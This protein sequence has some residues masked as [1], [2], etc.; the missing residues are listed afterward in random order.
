MSGGYVLSALCFAAISLVTCEISCR[1]EAGAS[2]D[3]FVVYKLPIRRI[4]A[5]AGP[6]LEYLYLDS[7]S[8]TWEV[9][10]F[11]INMSQGAV[12]RTL[13]QL[14]QSYNTNDTA[15]MMYNDSPPG[16]NNYTTQRGHSKG[17][18]FFDRFQGF[19][20]IH[21]VPHFP[22]FP[23][24]GFG[25]PHTGQQY[26]QSAICVTYRYDQFKEIASQ[27]LYYNPNAYNCSVPDLYHKELWSLLRICQGKSFPWIE[28]TR[29]V[30]LES[31]QGEVF[32]NFAK[33]KYFVDDIYAAWIAQK[34]GSDLLSETWQP[35]GMELPSNCS[36]P[37]HVYNIKRLAL[38]KISFYSL[39]DH[40]K[41]CV[42]KLGEDAWTCIG[43]LNRYPAQK[44]RSGGFI[45]TQNAVIYRAFSGMV[46]YYKA[47]QNSTVYTDDSTY[48]H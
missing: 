35:A 2:V 12:G 18:L 36:L 31:A 10:R 42:S 28:T 25:Y 7:T 26:G 19:W 32:L 17:T 43:D 29:L 6:G 9:S 27:L 34:L 21:S 11:L 48:S 30:P 5:T 46:A 41:W 20:L 39:Y 1:N 33:S 4:N 37:R 44:W 14:Y 3:W 38:P 23:E 8:Q 47:C 13:Q 15:Y 45:C 40:S 24:D 22:P 16:T